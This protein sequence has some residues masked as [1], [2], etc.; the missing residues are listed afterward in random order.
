MVMITSTHR[1]NRQISHERGFTLI[2]LMIVVAIIGVL[3]AI[4]YPSYQSYVIK[5]K[6]VD[7][8]TEMQQI[9]SR[10]EA[11]KITYRRYDRIPLSEIFSNTVS[12][13]STTFPNNGTALYTVEITAFDGTAFDDRDW[14]LTAEPI[15]GGQMEDGSLTLDFEGKKCRGSDTDK[16]C[17]FGDEWND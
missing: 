5:T 17:G 6:R 16:V 14:L 12:G 15:S 4:A 1:Q 2:E 8:M 7:M 11:N 3:A 10:I 13:A 9:A